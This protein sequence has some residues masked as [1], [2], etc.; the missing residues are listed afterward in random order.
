MTSAP[1]ERAAF[2]FSKEENDD[3]TKVG[4]GSLLGELFRQYWIPVLP[5]SFLEEQDGNPRRVRLLGEDL[6]LFRS[7]GGAVG[8]IGAFCSHRL[9]P[10]FFGR[11]EENGLRCPYHGWKYTPGGQCLEMPN[12]PPEQEFKNDIH[13]RGYPCV[14]H[15]RIVWAYMGSAN[16]M[17]LLP[18]F[19]FT[20]VPEAQRIYRLFRQEC[21]YLQAMEGGIDPT[22]V[23]WLHSPYDLTD[24]QIAE[25]HQPIPQRLANASGARTPL[26]IEIVDTTCGFMYGAKRPVADGRSLWRVNQFLM[27]F[28]TMPPGGKFRLARAWIPIDDTHCVK[29]DIGW[30]PTASIME[31]A[32]AGNKIFFDEESYTSPSH[33]PYGF[34]CPKANKANNYSIDW[35]VHKER[36]LGVPGVNLQDICITE[37]EGPGPILERPRENLCSGDGTIIKARRMLL[38]CAQEFRER[39]TI[40]PGLDN[41]RAYRVRGANTIV[42]DTVAWVEGVRQEVTA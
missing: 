33:E 14:E 39:G 30:F 18:E 1:S 12:V 31:S 10:L 5:T 24:Q 8:L 11:I 42:P 29:W 16:K 25:S 22:H 9:A 28:Y 19:E 17:P 13:H 38:R 37:N 32:E 34:I 41:P 27:P 2:A 4:P 40:P 3:L 23:M 20:A 6:V 35:E 26:A 7:G 36:R 21:N 15:A